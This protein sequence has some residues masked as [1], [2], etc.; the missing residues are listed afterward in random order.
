MFDIE[1]LQ[2]IDNPEFFGQAKRIEFV[3]DDLS[4]KQEKVVGDVNKTVYCPQ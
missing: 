4:K 1:S 2:T 3:L